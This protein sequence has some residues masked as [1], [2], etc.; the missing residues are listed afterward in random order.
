M[1]SAPFVFGDEVFS[2]ELLIKEEFFFFFY[3]NSETEY[4]YEL[5]D[6]LL[7][8]TRVPPKFLFASGLRITFVFR[9]E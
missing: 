2:F 7:V 6:D 9:K 5:Y 3:E 4:T 1:D 8:L